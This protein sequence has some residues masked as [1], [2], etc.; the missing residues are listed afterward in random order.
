MINATIARAA[1][2][3]EQTLSMG[4]SCLRETLTAAAAEC[5]VV[6]RVNIAEPLRRRGP[7]RAMKSPSLIIIDMVNDFLRTL[8][9]AARQRLLRSTNEL[10]GIVRSCGRPVI[11]VRQQFRADLSD[12]FLEMR[13]KG[14]RVTI[15]GTP[16]C[17]IAA[18][19]A[20]VSRM[21]RGPMR[22]RATPG[23][24]DR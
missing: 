3:H 1:E 19:L 11:W 4:L 12:A 9:P 8:E 15:E 22:G 20:V 5:K 13:R 24:R 10:I 17:E 2:C 21:E 7:H 6:S 18:D 23:H 16:G 14:I